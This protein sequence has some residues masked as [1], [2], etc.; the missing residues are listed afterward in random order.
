MRRQCA[1]RAAFYAHPAGNTKTGIDLCNIPGGRDHGIVVL[2]YGFQPAAAAGAAV[3]D[4]IE[5]VQAVFLEERIMHMT[6]LVFI[7]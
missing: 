2:Q 6:A 7:P 1:G 4:D 5:T 3:A